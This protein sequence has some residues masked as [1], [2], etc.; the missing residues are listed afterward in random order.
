MISNSGAVA[1][2]G[3]NISDCAAYEGTSCTATWPAV[4]ANCPARPNSLAVASATYTCTYSKTAPSI[5]DSSAT[6]NFVNNA[7][8]TANEISPAVS[9]VTAQFEKPADL[10]VVKWVS[11]Y[12]LGNDGDGTPSFGTGDISMT[13]TGS[14]GPVVWYYVGITNVGAKTANNVAISDTMGAIPFGQNNATAVCDANPGSMAAGAAFTCRYQRTLQTGNAARA[15]TVSVTSSNVVPNGDD[16]ATRTVDVSQCTGGS[17]VPNMIGMTKTQATTAWT[18]A[19]FKS[20]KITTWSN[21]DTDVVADPGPPGRPLP[22]RQQRHR[23]GQAGDHA[24]SLRRRRSR[25]QALTEFALVLPIF[26]LLLFGIIDVA[27]LAFTMNTLNNAAREAARGIA[28]AKWPPACNGMTSGNGSNN[29]RG[30]CAVAVSRSMALGV[31]G[32]VN[33]LVT[34]CSIGNNDADGDGVLDSSQVALT[35]T[36]P[37][38]ATG[39]WRLCHSGDLVKVT[40]SSQF[41][42]VTPLI[43]RF[44][45]QPILRGEAQVSVSSS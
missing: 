43:S 20:N 4:S 40:T 3:M 24:M 22:E 23:H 25:G 1:L 44:V 15:N 16:S 36:N 33:I 34:C 28:V 13:Y 5:P 8:V 31:S 12:P 6:K 2:T 45:G 17:V 7:T 26:A 21:F 18:T 32:T 37:V 11:P 30:D 10:R 41:T 38:Q 42:L 9:A 35:N 14:T 19:G 29:Q 27:R 39:A